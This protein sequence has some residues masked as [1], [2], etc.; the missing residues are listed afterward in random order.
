MKLS[1]RVGAKLLDFLEGITTINANDVMCQWME[2]Y[3]DTPLSARQSLWVS[4]ANKK[5]GE[6]SHEILSVEDADRKIAKAYIPAEVIRLSGEWSFQAFIRQYSITAPTK[7]TQASTNVITFTVSN[8]LPLDSD[9]SPVTDATIAA[10]YETAK[11]AAVS[12]Y[13]LKVLATDDV[14]EEV[15][16]KYQ[17]RVAQVTHNFKKI[18]SIV[19]QRKVTNDY[20]ENMIFSYKIYKS[21]S[22]AVIV[23][24]KIDIRIVIKGTSHI[25]DSTDSDDGVITFTLNKVSGGTSTIS[26]RYTTGMTWRALA[27]NYPN[28]LFSSRYGPVQA[29]TENTAVILTEYVDET[30]FTGEQWWIARTNKARVELD[31]VIVGDEYLVIRTI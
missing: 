21:G 7:Y 14:W 18:Y 23:D 6:H 13:E 12:M 28:Y 11:R 31:D 22:V 27:L 9:D 8:G 15:N 17:V 1:L 20:Y 16:G 3:L 26:F 25:S 4:Y 24:K 2:I 29:D 10:L 19:A 5:Y 30:G